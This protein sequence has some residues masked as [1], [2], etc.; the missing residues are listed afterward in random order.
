[1]LLGE[2]DAYEARCRAHY[3]YEA[4]EEQALLPLDE[5]KRVATAQL[6]H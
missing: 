1:V 6:G 3:H 4:E 5:E 2:T